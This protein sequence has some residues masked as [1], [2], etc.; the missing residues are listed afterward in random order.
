MK[1][2]DQSDRVATVLLEVY[3]LDRAAFCLA[4]ASRRANSFEPARVELVVG[5]VNRLD[6][7]APIGLAAALR[8]AQVSTTVESAPPKEGGVADVVANANALDSGVNR[9]DVDSSA[10]HQPCTMMSSRML[11][12]RPDDAAAARARLL[13]SSS[14]PRT[15]L[16][17][18]PN[19][20]LE[21][22]LLSM[23]RSESRS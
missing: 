4:D 21:M 7:Q 17:G 5:S 15:S 20:S 6:G 22:P 16:V 14:K 10:V 2:R 18:S 11:R 3:C 1:E 8:A 13:N 9:G 23:L 12:S 19:P